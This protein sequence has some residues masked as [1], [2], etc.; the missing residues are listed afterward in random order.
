MP[1]SSIEG[2]TF[3]IPVMATWMRGIEV[4]MRPLPSL[5]TSTSVPVSA[6]MK[7]APVMPMSAAMN[8]SRSWRRASWARSSMPVYRGALSL[9]SN[10]SET[11][12]RDL[13]IAGA[14][15][16]N[17]ASPASWIMYSPRSVSTDSMPASSRR[18]FSPISSETMDLLLTTVLTPL[19]VAR[20]VT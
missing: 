15:M 10:S 19:A 4:H 11:S 9:S 3:S 5:V 2:T 13:W 6:T 8:F 12:S 1:M 7:F 14:I 16:W 17:G 20:S 18:S